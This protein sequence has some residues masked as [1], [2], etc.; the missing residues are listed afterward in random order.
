MKVAAD[1]VIPGRDSEVEGR[2]SEDGDVGGEGAEERLKEV[3]QENL[4]FVLVDSVQDVD[5]EREEMATG[6]AKGKSVDV[7]GVQEAWGWGARLLHISVQ[8]HCCN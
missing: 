4:V 3:T 6:G 1:V 5:M 2:V 7:E 8:G